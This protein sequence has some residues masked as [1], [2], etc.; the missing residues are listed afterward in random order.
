MKGFSSLWTRLC[1]FKL[2]LLERDLWQ[3]SQISH[4]CTRQ[5]S[6]HKSCFFPHPRYLRNLFSSRIFR[7]ATRNY[8]KCWPKMAQ[9]AKNLVFSSPI[10]WNGK[11][12]AEFRTIFWEFFLGPGL[13][14]FQLPKI[15]NLL[16]C[17]KLYKVLLQG[18]TLL[19]LELLLL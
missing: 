11:N 14:S 17:F 9:S 18:N 10:M 2:P 1:C 19:F 4:M 16:Q 15:F 6:G 7:G 8:V 3:I 12:W 5:Y 13:L